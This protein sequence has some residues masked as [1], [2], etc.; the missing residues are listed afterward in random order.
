MKYLTSAVVLVALFGAQTEQVNAVQLKFSDDLIKSLTEDIQKDQNKQDEQEQIAAAQKEVLDQANKEH[1]KET[2]ATKKEEKSAKKDTK[3]DSKKQEK[4]KAAASGKKDAKSKKAE[5][6]V[7][8]KKEEEDIPMDQAAIKAYSSVIADAAEDSEPQ[9]PVE[10]KAIEVEKEVKHE[11][12]G[13]NPDP[14]GSMIQNEIS[15][16]KEAS[17]KAARESD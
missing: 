12:E 1:E 10:Y 9:H 2:K 8:A 3:K 7:E 14:M 11:H 15:N 16:I 17:I 13:Y 6:K 5:P 4:G